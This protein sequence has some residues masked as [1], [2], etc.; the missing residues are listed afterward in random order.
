MAES[1]G[2]PAEAAVETKNPIVE[3]GTSM[4]NAF[5]LVFTPRELSS[6]GPSSAPAEAL[7]STCSV[8]AAAKETVSD[9]P[10]KVEMS[11]LMP[12][13]PTTSPLASPP[14][15]RHSLGPARSNALEDGDDTNLDDDD[16]VAHRGHCRTVRDYSRPPISSSFPRPQSAPMLQCWLLVATDVPPTMYSQRHTS[17]TRRRPIQ[18]SRSS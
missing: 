18:G 12:K 8:D 10:N 7:S 16:A 13:S 5:V 14:P 6:S 4:L 1:G 9:T 11:E 15:Q 2:E 3:V 17:R